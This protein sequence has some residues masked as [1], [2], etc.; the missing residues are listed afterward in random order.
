VTTD[1]AE[2]VAR[3][4]LYEGYA[5]YPYR[6]SS[7]KNR[8]R[9]MFGTLYP[10]AFCR[11]ASAGDRFEMATECLVKADADG[12]P[13]VRVAVRFLELDGTSD[14]TNIDDPPAASERSIDPGLLP[15][16]AEDS[17]DSVAI[18]TLPRLA[19][20]VTARSTPL[21]EH[22]FKIRVAIANTTDVDD[23]T[24]TRALSLFRSL[25]SVH[26][27]LRCEGG[28]FVSLLEPPEELAPRISSLVSDGLWPVL[29]GEPHLASTMLA[30]PIILYDCPK[31]A[32]E[33][34]GDLFDATEIDEILTLRILTLT[35][36]ERREM[37][38]ADPRCR[39]I[40]ERTLALD[41]AALASLHGAWRE[42]G[43]PSAKAASGHAFRRGDR[44]VVK[45]RPQGDV[46]DIA[47]AGEAATITS[48]EE[49][50][51]GRVLFGVTIDSD[52]GK[53]LGEQGRPGH[54]FFFAREDLERAP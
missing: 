30:S 44:V 26:A 43:A 9:W 45:P 39:A 10:P 40:L 28:K 32:P 35:E 17:T 52:P 42:R 18:V 4:L 31:V 51:E 19:A 54:R 33:S 16:V 36:E 23:P 6:P 24:M 37:A 14:R 3:A 41:P 13:S 38:R 50:L 53:D 1:L 12:A 27:I 48:I 8:Q 22:L 11:A 5:L 2:Q 47:L 21:G 29:I 15:L 7:L 34:P 20:R 49:D 25:V 46:L